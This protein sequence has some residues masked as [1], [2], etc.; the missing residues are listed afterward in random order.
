MKPARLLGHQIHPMVIVFPLGLLAISVIFDLAYLATGNAAF[1][2]TAYWNIIAGVVGGLLAAVFGSWDWLTIPRGTRAKRIGALHGS[3]NVVVVALFLANWMSRRDEA[4]HAPTSATIIMSLVA[5]GFALVAGWLGGELVERLGIGVWRDA[6]PNAPSSL[7]SS[8]R[9][10]A[11]G[12]G[13]PSK[14]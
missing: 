2:E 6:E 5:V 13:A 8:T 9:R 3:L 12:E 10:G 1:A 7:R 4:F 11:P 14:V